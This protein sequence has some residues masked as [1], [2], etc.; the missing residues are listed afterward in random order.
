VR[1]PSA[2]VTALALAISLAQANEVIEEQN[3][4]YWPK[5]DMA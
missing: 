2:S 1:E 4:R 5:A 3:V